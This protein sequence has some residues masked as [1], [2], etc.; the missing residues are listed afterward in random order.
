ML[1]L[2]ETK[3]HQRFTQK[4]KNINIFAFTTLNIKI[5]NKGQNTK[6]VNKQTKIQQQT[7]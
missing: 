6:M 5:I 1:H 2:N 7:L 3:I 4:V